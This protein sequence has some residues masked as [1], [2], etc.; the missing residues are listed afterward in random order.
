MLTVIAYTAYFAIQIL[1]SLTGEGAEGG[2][3]NAIPEQNAILLK[4][5]IFDLLTEYQGRKCFLQILLI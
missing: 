3:G 5:L 2:W 4:T 1:P